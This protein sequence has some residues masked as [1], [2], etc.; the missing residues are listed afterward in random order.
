MPLTLEVLPNFP[1]RDTLNVPITKNDYQYNIYI[2]LFTAFTIYKEHLVRRPF[3]LNTRLARLLSIAESYLL[4]A[5]ADIYPARSQLVPTAL[6]QLPAL[7]A[8]TH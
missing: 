7:A 1:F 4:V 8:A 2:S 5:T 6:H 3:S